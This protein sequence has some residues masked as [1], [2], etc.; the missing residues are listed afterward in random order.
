MDQPWSENSVAG[1]LIN[2]N[3]CFTDPPIVTEEKWMRA[4]LGDR[5]Q[6]RSHSG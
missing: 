2:P 5:Q 4:I 6:P 1:T 3:Y